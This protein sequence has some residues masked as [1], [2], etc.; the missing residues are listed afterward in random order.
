MH[1]FGVLYCHTCHTTFPTAQLWDC[2][3]FGFSCRCA[4]D[5]TIYRTTVYRNDGLLKDSL[6]NRQVIDFDQTKYGR[7][8]RTIFIYRM[9]FTIG[10]RKAFR[11]HISITF[12]RERR[13][14]ARDGSSSRVASNGN[15]YKRKIRYQ[16]YLFL[17][18][19]NV[20]L[21]HDRNYRKPFWFSGYA[22]GCNNLFQFGINEPWNYLWHCYEKASPSPLP[23]F[24]KGKGQCTQGCQMVPHLPN[25]AKNH[26]FPKHLPI[27]LAIFFMPKFA[28]FERPIVTMNINNIYQLDTKTLEGTAQIMSEYDLL[29][30]ELL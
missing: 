3:G 11:M 29:L 6:W 28:I 4:R 9:N 17:F 27:F 15:V 1:Y 2:C 14:N 16:S 13:A 12:I 24:S 30:A 23:V 10:I 8:N 18:S 26:S 7:F 25:I 20:D 21:K 19:N 5:T 22:R